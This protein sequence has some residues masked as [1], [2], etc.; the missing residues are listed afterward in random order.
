MTEDHKL[1]DFQVVLNTTNSY[2][3][4]HIA[5][6]RHITDENKHTCTRTDCRTVVVVKSLEKKK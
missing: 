2:R 3:N 5:A 6:R 1:T 4:R